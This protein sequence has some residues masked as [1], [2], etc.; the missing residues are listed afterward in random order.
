MNRHLAWLFMGLAL[1]LAG[2]PGQ[3]ASP[4]RALITDPVANAL[5]S[6]RAEIPVTVSIDNYQQEIA[7]R[8][9]FWV[10]LANVDGKGHKIN[11]WPKFYVKAPVYTGKAYEGGFNP[12][13]QPQPMVILLLK[14]DDATNQRFEQWMKDGPSKGYP[15]FRVD[16]RQIIAEQPIRLP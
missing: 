7:A 4:P 2:A 13:P 3:A 5:L 9:H 8:W 15:G 1:L 6:T 16:P 12:L 10:S 14:V 11:H